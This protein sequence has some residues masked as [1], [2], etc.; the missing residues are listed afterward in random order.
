M[1][2]TYWM[3]FK[4]VIMHYVTLSFIQPFWKINSRTF[5]WLFEKKGSATFLGNFIENVKKFMRILN[6]YT[7]FSPPYRLFFWND[8]QHQ[9]FWNCVYFHPIRVKNI[10]QRTH[11][12]ASEAFSDGFQLRPETKHIYLS[13]ADSY[14]S[15][16]VP[17]YYH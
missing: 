10:R 13:Q 4:E 16:R 7:F 11:M 3:W 8:L 9:E 14:K 6:I 2:W 12:F 15:A 17:F 5:N 1:K